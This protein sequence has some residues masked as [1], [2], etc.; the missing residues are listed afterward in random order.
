MELTRG[1]NLTRDDLWEWLGDVADQAT[2]QGAI[3]QEQE[4]QHAGVDD[5]VRAWRRLHDAAD[6]LDARL[7]RKDYYGLLDA[8]RPP[9]ALTVG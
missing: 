2:V 4:G 1:K 8:Q 9:G 6:A 5:D 3:A 7:R